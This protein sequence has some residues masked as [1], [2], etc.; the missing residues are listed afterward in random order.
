MLYSE[1]QLVIEPGRGPCQGPQ[2]S[3][4]TAPLDRTLNPAFR[5]VPPT[6]WR[7]AGGLLPICLF[8]LSSSPI[9][10][11]LLLPATLVFLPFYLEPM[12]WLHSLKRLR[13]TPWPIRDETKT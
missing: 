5:Q 3:P 4:G 12:M 9:L 11:S 10:G 7:L 2:E 13:V 1:E 8:L 6:G